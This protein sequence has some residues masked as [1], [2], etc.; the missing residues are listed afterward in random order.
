M[1]TDTTSPIR[2]DKSDALIVIHCADHEWYRACRFHLDDARDAAC[3]HEEREH[4][5]DNRHREARRLRKLRRRVTPP[6]SH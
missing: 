6:A 1:T 3:A 2:L 5:M 4:A